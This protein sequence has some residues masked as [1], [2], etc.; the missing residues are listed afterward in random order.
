M[1]ETLNRPGLKIVRAETQNPPKGLAKTHYCAATQLEGYNLSHALF[2]TI[3]SEAQ[4][5]RGALMLQNLV[6]ASKDA[7]VATKEL[8]QTRLPTKGF[9]ATI[10]GLFD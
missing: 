2:S 10:S 6:K 3:E 4:G 5:S 7:S 8:S 9:R 1:I